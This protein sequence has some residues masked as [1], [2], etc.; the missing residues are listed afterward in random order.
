MSGIVGIFHRDGDFLAADQLRLMTDFLN[1]RGP[2]GQDIWQGSCVGFG[3][4]LLNVFQEPSRQTQ[5]I[6]LES[7]WITAD[8]RLDSKADLLRKLQAIGRRS[9]AHAC[10]AELILHAYA[11]WG[12]GCLEHLRGDFSFVVWD[13]VAKTLFCARDHF[14]IKPFYYA[15]LGKV[16]IFSNTLNCLRQHPRVGN[17]LNEE[18]IGDFLLFGWNYNESSSSFRD[19]QRLP[20]AHW[21]LVS[22]EGLH[23]ERYWR[24]PTQDRIRYTRSE[25]YVDNFMELFHAAV[26]DRLPTD[27]AGIL[28]GGGLDSGAVAAVA[29]AFAKSQGGSPSLRSYTAGYDRLIPD[30]DNVFARQSAEHVGIP[31]EFLPLDNIDLFEET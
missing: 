25:D 23:A 1:Y 12:T 16:F 19:I 7:L 2:D 24:P 29:S 14:G 22:R 4:T 5:P 26:V 10:D 21:L 11:A 17:Q 3:H 13:S 28:L 8:V 27:R 9:E 30:N 31:N 20:P 18:A 15:D 6:H